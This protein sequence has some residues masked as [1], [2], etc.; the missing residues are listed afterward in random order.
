MTISLA[1]IPIF[2]RI[3]ICSL[4]E[5]IGI[6]DTSHL[7]SVKSMKDAEARVFQ[8]AEAVLGDGENRR[9]RN[10]FEQVWDRTDVS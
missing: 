4:A 9:R 7:T 10:S 8:D 5:A 2:M 1:S 3:H 6:R